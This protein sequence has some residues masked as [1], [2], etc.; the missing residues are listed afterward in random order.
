MGLPQDSLLVRVAVAGRT[1]LPPVA[2]RGRALAHSARNSVGL[3]PYA[4]RK[5]RLKTT[6]PLK[7]QRAATTLTWR[8]RR[9]GQRL[10][11]DFGGK[12][13]LGVQVLGQASRR[14]VDGDRAETTQ[15]V[16]TAFGAVVFQRGHEGRRDCGHAPVAGDAA[17]QHLVEAL[18]A[19]PLLDLFTET[20]DAATGRL[21]TCGDP[22]GRWF[23]GPLRFPGPGWAV[24]LGVRFG[25]PF[26]AR[27]GW[28]GGVTG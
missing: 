12:L 21:P 9:P 20:Q 2:D 28:S 19:Q 26:G 5:E 17:G 14:E 18:G 24:R 25:V 23:L 6:G 3:S 22:V 4:S 15:L 7:P 16:R 11:P 10:R 27:F 8:A 13:I 1:A